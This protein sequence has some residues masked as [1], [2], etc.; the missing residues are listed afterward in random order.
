[1]A[2]PRAP[3][4]VLAAGTRL[5][6]RR[7]PHKLAQPLGDVERAR[8]DARAARSPATCTSSS[9]PPR[10]SPTSRGSSVAARDVV[11][12]PEVGRDGAARSAWASRSP[13]ASRVRP[14]AAGWLVLPGDMPLVQP[15]T[16]LAVA[17]AL[18]HHAGR[19]RPAPRPARPSGRL[20]RRAVLRAAA[21]GGD[22]GARRMHRPLSGASASSSTIPASWSTSTPR[23][24]S[25]RAA[26]RAAS[27]APSVG[28]RAERAGV[29]AQARQRVA[30]RQRDQALDVA[31]AD[32][33]VAQRVARSPPGRRACCRSGRWRCA[34]S[35]ASARRRAR[36]V[37]LGLRAAEREGEGRARRRAACGRRATSGRRRRSASRAPR[38]AAAPPRRATARSGRRG[39]GT[40]RRAPARTPGPDI[41]ACRG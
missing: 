39:R 2:A 6:V 32:A 30:A 5:P 3:S 22:E 23:T 10:R 4:I 15:S 29:A 7:R 21:L 8:A 33:A 18:D 14:H 20:R 16:L 9:S 40:S 11:V 36:P 31:V 1:M 13:P 19:L 12:L 38:G 25:K 35:R 26:R 41:P 24:I 27:P 17:R 34:G 37:W 28:G